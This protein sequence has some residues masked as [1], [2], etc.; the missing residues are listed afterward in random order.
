MMKI[1]SFRPKKTEDDCITIAE[2]FEQKWNFPKCPP[3]SGS[4]YFN[5]KGTFSAVLMAL[6]DGDYNFVYIDVGIS[7]E[8][9]IWKST[10]SVISSSSWSLSIS[11]EH[12]FS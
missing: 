1:F 2:K 12:G 6:V 10:D 7:A 8:S 4:F 3:K 11:L 9:A 5:Y